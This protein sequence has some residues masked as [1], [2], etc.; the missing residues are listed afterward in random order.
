M[1][2][3]DIRDLSGAFRKSINPSMSVVLLNIFNKECRYN[4]GGPKRLTT[5]SFLVYLDA[6][7]EHV[8]RDGFESSWRP[9]RESRPTLAK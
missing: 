2:D 3:G 1:S 4:E 9:W 8:G 7:F 6:P 5:F